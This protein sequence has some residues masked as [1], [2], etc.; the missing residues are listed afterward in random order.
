MIQ[1][2]FVYDASGNLM[3]SQKTGRVLSDCD[4]DRFSHVM[5]RMIH[6][7]TSEIEC[8]V[9]GDF[10]ICYLV[11]EYVTL[12]IIAERSDSEVSLTRTCQKLRERIVPLIRQGRLCEISQVIIENVYEM[13]IKISLFG[14]PAVGK[15]TISCLI[16]RDRIPLVHNATIGVEVK[17]VPEG[18]FGPNRGLVLWDI[19][20]QSRFSSIWPRYLSG[21]SLVINITDSSL[22]STL[23]S[24][25]MLSLVRKSAPDAALLGVANKQD[26]PQALTGSRVESILG[27]PTIELCAIDALSSDTRET[28]HNAIRDALGMPLDDSEYDGDSASACVF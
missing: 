24:K 13:S 6:S 5:F 16:M 8:S 4:T 7:A 28:M 22:R 23:W 17:M 15:T 26:L 18:I 20:G 11:S 3:V 2:V 1:A 9:L 19:G 27:I 25:K 10:T 14:L 21:S 12:I